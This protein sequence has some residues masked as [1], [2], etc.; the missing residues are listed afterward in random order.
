MH[1]ILQTQMLASGESRIRPV[2]RLAAG[3]LL[4][5]LA[6]VDSKRAFRDLDDFAI[7]ARMVRLEQAASVYSDV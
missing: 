2:V 5:H 6:E 1:L 4:R 7:Y 3:A